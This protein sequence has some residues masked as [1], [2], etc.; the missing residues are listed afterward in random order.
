MR[1]SENEVA[2]SPLSQIYIIIFFYKMCE[3][4]IKVFLICILPPLSVKPIFEVNKMKYKNYKSHKPFFA[5]K[6]FYIVLLVCIMAVGAAAWGAIG[7]INSVDK[8]LETEKPP[9]VSDD[10][11]VGKNVSDVQK[12]E[13]PETPVESEP[14]PPAESEPENTVS[15][16]SDISGMEINPETVTVPPKFAIPLNGNIGKIFSDSELQYSATYK[17]MRLHLGVD[18][19]A[20]KG[21]EVVSAAAGDV[22]KVANDALWGKMVVIDHGSGIVCYYCGL[23]DTTVSEGETISA[24]TLIGKVGT[25]PCES[26]DKSH[27][28]IAVTRDGQ[29]ISPLDLMKN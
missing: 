4:T 2:A 24:G 27:I 19:Q 6:G 10:L 15:I 22:K 9:V 14:T 11:D 26:A 5:G 16:P 21:A 3:Q 28:H 13:I 29:Y 8:D 12:E 1:D 20:E 7:T 18:V 25:V 17:D 23:E